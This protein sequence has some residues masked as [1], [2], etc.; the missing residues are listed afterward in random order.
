MFSR[1]AVRAT[2]A[3]DGHA[4]A[5]VCG[6]AQFPQGQQVQPRVAE[7]ESQVVQPPSMSSDIA[8]LSR[9]APMGHRE[10]TST[11]ITVA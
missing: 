11:D 6:S 5:R 7:R 8:P 4:Q 1:H 3:L 9:S 10:S 2:R